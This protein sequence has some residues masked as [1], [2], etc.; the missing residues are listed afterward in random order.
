[1]GSA[2]KAVKKVT[3]VIKRPISKITKGIA[4]GIAKVGKATMRGVGRLNKKFGPLGMIALSVAMP[5]AMQGLSNVIGRGAMSGIH[6]PTGFMGS[7]NIF[8]RS[9]G[10]VGNKIRTGYNGITGTVGRKFTSITDSIREGFGSMGKGDNIFSRISRGAKDLFKNSKIEARKYKPF[11]SKGGSVDVLN[12]RGSIHGE[13]M[14]TSSMSNTQAA[15]LLESG[16]IQGDQLV[17]QSFG[18]PGWI[19]KANSVDKAVSEAINKTY[20]ENVMSSWSN[21]AKKAF[22]DYKGAADASGQSYNYQNIHKVMEPNLNISGTSDALTEFNFAKSGDYILQNPNEPTSYVFNGNKSFNVK[23]KSTISKV[24]SAAKVA[25]FGATQSLLKPTKKAD[26]FTLPI[27]LGDM[28]QET[29]GATMYGGTTI[30]G[31]AGGSLLEG[32]YDRAA[33]EKILNYYKHMNIVGSH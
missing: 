7:D 28:T 17:G 13:G 14:I 8:L 33:Q 30:E 9:I 26:V 19:T 24:K 5:Y 23:G 6:G 32:V 4:R 10:N 29:D 21:S 11:T 25:K 20:E 16:V 31:S 2:V 15:Q 1:M 3:K 18:K 12:Y 27:K 22:A